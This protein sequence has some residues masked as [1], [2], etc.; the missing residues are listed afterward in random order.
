MSQSL[1]FVGSKIVVDEGKHSWCSRHR[2]CLI[3]AT[4]VTTVLIID[5][6]KEFVKF[7]WLLKLGTCQKFQANAKGNSDELVR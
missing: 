6:F 2:S 4:L 5:G 1:N 7:Y 3:L